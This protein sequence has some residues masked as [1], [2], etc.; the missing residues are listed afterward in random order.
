MSAQRQPERTGDSAV[1]ISPRKKTVPYEGETRRN[2]GTDHGF[3]NLKLHPELVDTVPELGSD[4]ALRRIMSA[5]DRPP[6]GLFSIACESR[7]ITDQRGS[8]LSGYLEFAL[9]C[10]N[11]AADAAQYFRIFQTFDGRLRQEGFGESVSFQWVLCPTRFVE[12]QLDGFAAEVR[13]DTAFH[14]DPV[15]AYECW[16]R[17]LAVLEATLAAFPRCSGPPIYP[18]ST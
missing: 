13:V 18:S 12:A 17:A 6:T 8:R 2:G 1:Q 3:K 15:V 14:L 10:R 4:P 16:S 9:N 11:E 7:R 5:I